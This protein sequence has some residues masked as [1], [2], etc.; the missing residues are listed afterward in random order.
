VDLEVA[1]DAAVRGLHQ[2]GSRSLVEDEAR[3][4]VARHLDGGHAQV[5]RVTRHRPRE[6]GVGGPVLR[7]AGRRGVDADDRHAGEDEQRPLA[8]RTRDPRKH[9]LDA[10]FEPPR[11]LDL[12][13]LDDGYLPRHRLRVRAERRR[14]LL[15][16]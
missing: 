5:P 6:L 12:D 15:D 14:L 11:A 16:G 1:Q 2:L 8:V 3:R 10:R 13:A 7:G 9:A 4:E